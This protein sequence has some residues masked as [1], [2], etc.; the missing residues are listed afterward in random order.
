MNST[1]IARKSH[2]IQA[3]RRTLILLM[4][5]QGA[6]FKIGHINNPTPPRPRHGA[7]SN[8][9]DDFHD[10]H[11]KRRNPINSMGIMNFS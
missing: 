8:K 7:F 2:A 10:L 3:C 6:A 11:G 1:E 4:K 9:I 5:T